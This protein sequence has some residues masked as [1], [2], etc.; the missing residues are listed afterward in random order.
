MRRLKIHGV[1]QHY[2]GDYYL[3]EDTARHSETGEEMVI[4]RQL[5]GDGGLYVRPMDLFL[6]EIDHKQHSEVKTKY[7][8]T[9]QNIK[10]VR[11]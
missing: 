10:S 1:Y 11:K 7:R 4:Y 6:S 5:Y 9:L 8:F 2:K 3:V